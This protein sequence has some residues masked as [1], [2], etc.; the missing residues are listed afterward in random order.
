MMRKP[1]ALGQVLIAL[2]T[3]RWLRASTWLHRLRSNTQSIVTPSV[4][5]R[6]LRASQISS[7]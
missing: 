2:P 5:A 1:N 6:A 3:R 7:A 4:F